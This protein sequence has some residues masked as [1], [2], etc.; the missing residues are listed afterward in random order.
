MKKKTK[1]DHFENLGNFNEQ[2]NYLIYGLSVDVKRIDYKLDRVLKENEEKI[3]P[4]AREKLAELSKF[5]AEFQSIQQ[6]TEKCLVMFNHIISEL[7]N[8]AT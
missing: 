5:M 2:P 4:T 6:Q 8:N 3:K 7:K 1:E